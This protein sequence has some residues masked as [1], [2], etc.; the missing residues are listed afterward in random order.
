MFRLKDM[1]CKALADPDY[2]GKEKRDGEGQGASVVAGGL[3]QIGCLI[4]T[5][6][7]GERGSSSAFEVAPGDRIP[8]FDP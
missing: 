5:W 4:G 2:A 8:G 6:Y 7:W 1:K 3:G